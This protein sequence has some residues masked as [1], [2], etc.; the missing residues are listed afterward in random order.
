MPTDEE[1][2]E[3]IE[4]GG[5]RFDTGEARPLT[6]AERIEAAAWAAIRAFDCEDAM[7]IFPAMVDLRAALEP[8]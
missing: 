2:C 3:A 5:R 4:A 7:A 6:R 8:A 1:L